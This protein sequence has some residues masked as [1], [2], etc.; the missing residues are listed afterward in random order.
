MAGRKRWSDAHD[1]IETPTG[2]VDYSFLERIAICV[3][4]GLS[5]REAM[6][7]AST[8]YQRAMLDGGGE[9]RTYAFW[10]LSDTGAVLAWVAAGQA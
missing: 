2:F 6:R 4:S 1:M 5:E 3:E 7:V 9:A 8:D 10:R